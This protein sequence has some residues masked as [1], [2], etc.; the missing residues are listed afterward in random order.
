MA[1]PFGSGHPRGHGGRGHPPHHT[2]FCPAQRRDR[3]G[4]SD[5]A[6]EP[7]GSHGEWLIKWVPARRFRLDALD[8]ESPYDDDMWELFPSPMSDQVLEAI[9]AGLNEAGT[10]LPA[11]K[12]FAAM[13][14]QGS[15][16][17]V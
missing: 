12:A 2:H 11:T 4:R 16:G 7:D 8:G 13:P 5:K 9:R 14:N 1:L 17:L 3:D 6:L 15:H 10:L